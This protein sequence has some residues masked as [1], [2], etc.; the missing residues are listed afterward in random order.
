MKT[1]GNKKDAERKA[2]QRAKYRARCK[3][4]KF[5]NLMSAALLISGLGI[6]STNVMA[7]TPGPAEIR[8]QWASYKDYQKSGDPQRKNTEDRIDISSPMIWGRLPIGEV[9]EIEASGVIDSVS[10]ASPFYLDSLSGAS[11][12]GIEDRRSAGDIKITR[13][14]E[15]YSLGIGYAGSIEDDYH[16]HSGLAEGKWWTADKN[17]TLAA[18]FAFDSD[19]ISST[20]NGLIDESK[21]TAHYLLGVTQ[22]LSPVDI[23]QTNLTLDSAQGYLSD[24]YK[25]LDARPR[26]RDS[27]AVLVRYNRYLSSIDA[28]LHSDYRIAHDSFGI[29]SHTFEMALYKPFSETWLVR[30]RVRYYSQRKASFFSDTFP[31]ENPNT[32]FYSADGRLGSFGGVTVGLKLEHDLG[33]GFTI[34]VTADYLEQR[35][36]WVIGGNGSAGVKQFYAP[37]FSAGIAKTF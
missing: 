15:R 31:P 26:S 29:T 24:P 34:N 18:S 28:S 20:N 21:H 36:G 30:P 2:L 10:G 6:S 12:T 1:C 16:S 37:F 35:P 13:Y 19:T 17:T 27:A 11:G 22:I 32:S 14:F 33:D 9:T 3:T 5:K 8:F 4:K 25:L 23:A 7:Q